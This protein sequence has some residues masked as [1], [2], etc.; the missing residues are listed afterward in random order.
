MFCLKHNSVIVGFTA[1]DIRCQRRSDFAQNQIFA[2]KFQIYVQPA[3]VKSDTI[4][5][6]TSKLAWTLSEKHRTKTVPVVSDN[7]QL[8]PTRLVNQPVVHYPLRNVEPMTS[9]RRPIVAGFSLQNQR[10]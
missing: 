4:F 3:S 2:L 7:P 1:I 10:H 9:T 6:H 8:Q 5:H